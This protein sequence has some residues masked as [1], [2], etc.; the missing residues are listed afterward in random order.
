MLF[1]VGCG[2]LDYVK[3]NGLDNESQLTIAAAAN[4]TQAFTEIGTAFEENND[5]NITFSFGSTNTLAEQIKNGAPFDIFA[6]ADDTT[7]EFLASEGYLISDTNALYA[8]GRIGLAT[9]K[10][11]RIKITTLEDLLNPDIIKVAIANPEHAPYGIAAKEA[12]IS[13]G[14]WEQI[15]PKL[16]YG[17]NISE[18]LTFITTGNAEA[19]IIALSLKDDNQINF[20]LIPNDLHKP[21]KQVMAVTQTTKNQVLARQFIDFVTSAEGKKI[22]SQYGF[23]APEE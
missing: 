17:K 10:N 21:L 7:V 5:C 9:N 18:T 2:S 12:L 15:E 22:L 8:L 20:S 14:L 16:V 19:G 13:A 23:E 1:L 11:S 4:L 3:N 6:S